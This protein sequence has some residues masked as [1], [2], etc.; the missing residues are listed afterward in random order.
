MPVATSKAVVKVE[1]RVVNIAVMAA[2]AVESA[3]AGEALI[4][5]IVVVVIA[6]AKETATEKIN[7]CSRFRK[8]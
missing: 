8:I 4:K 7:L 6:V 1:V 2:N 5:E 3:L